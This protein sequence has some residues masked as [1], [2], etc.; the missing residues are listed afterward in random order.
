[1][2]QHNYYAFQDIVLKSG[3]VVGIY[4]FQNQISCS[5]EIRTGWVLKHICIVSIIISRVQNVQMSLIVLSRVSVYFKIF[6]ER[7]QPAFLTIV[8]LAWKLTATAQKPIPPMINISAMAS[9][10]YS[11]R[12]II[13]WS[14]I[15][16]LTL[17]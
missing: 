6:L 7:E 4:L 3:W 14:M 13:L 16:T 12:A 15:T 11:W 1:M 2:K 10:L 17:V 9:L 8:V 5:K